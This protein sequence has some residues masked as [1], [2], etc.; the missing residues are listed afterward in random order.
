M[1]SKV[2]EVYPLPDMEL[3]VLFANGTAKTYDVKP[4]TGR[5]QTFKA[6][7]DEDLFNGVAV[8][9]GGYGVIWNDELDLSCGELWENGVTAG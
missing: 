4:L 8:D 1:F 2:E 6:L 5:L 9:E 7:E 3:S